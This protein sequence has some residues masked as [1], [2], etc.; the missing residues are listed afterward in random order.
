MRDH[1]TN[2]QWSVKDPFILVTGPLGASM[3]R[4]K[5]IEYQNMQEIC[6]DEFDRW[7][8]ELIHQTA[9]WRLQRLKG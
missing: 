9:I 6:P 5:C 1:I 2:T 4:S 3:L 7:L 8:H